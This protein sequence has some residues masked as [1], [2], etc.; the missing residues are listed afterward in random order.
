MKYNYIMKENHNSLP[1]IY[2]S[3]H[4]SKSVGSA[5]EFINKAIND[6]Y[7][8]YIRLKPI[9]DSHDFG[10]IICAMPTGDIDTFN[11]SISGFNKTFTIVEVGNLKA[12]FT[13][14]PINLFRAIIRRGSCNISH[15]QIQRESKKE[16]L[17]RKLKDAIQNYQ[18]AAI[19]R[20]QINN[21][22]E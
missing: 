8:F 20:D 13:P 9:I 10:E 19:L 21:L 22:N 7:L 12:L 16:E 1:I 3:E 18:L 2:W 17:I 15:I 11:S 5:I 6:G 14:P 4:K